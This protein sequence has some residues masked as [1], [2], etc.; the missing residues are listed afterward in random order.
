MSRGTPTQGPDDR[1]AWDVAVVGC[2][3]VGAALAVLLG[4]QGHRVVVVERHRAPYVLPRAVHF[5]HEV[6][7]ILQACGLGEQLPAISEPSS[8]YEWRNGAGE[9][10]LRFGGR[11]VGPSGWPDFNMFWQPALER[12]LTDAAQALPTVEVRRGLRVV[13]L[14][15][16][17]PADEP[18]VLVAEP[19]GGG[20]PSRIAARYVVGCDGA[21][22]TV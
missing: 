11:P 6:G 7:R 4:Q 2:G 21:N 12:L 18:V 16:A 19:A 10:L 20:A 15:Q 22:S 1:P 8:D 17:G 3:P 9:V 5:D 13:D 14:E